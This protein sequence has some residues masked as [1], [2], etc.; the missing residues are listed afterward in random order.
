MA[1]TVTEIRVDWL[2]A[3]TSHEQGATALLNKGLEIIEGYV[4]SGSTRNDWSFQGYRGTRCESSAVGWRVDGC[5]IRLGGRAA[6]THWNNVVPLAGHVSRFDCAVTIQAEQGSGGYARAAYRSA[7]EAKPSVGRK[8]ECT[9]LIST[10]GGE[11]AYIGRRISDR[12]L[13]IYNKHAE[14]RGAYP[15]GT[16]RYEVEY[17]SGLAEQVARALILSTDSDQMLMNTVHEEMTRAGVVPPWEIDGIEAVRPTTV[18][19]QLDNARR[20]EWLKTSVRNSIDRLTSSYSEREILTALG[21]WHAPSM[22]DPPI[23]ATSDRK[24]RAK[25]PGAP[26]D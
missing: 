8:P 26:R 25:I 18:R 20:M 19:D 5:C 3:T 23:L 7:I 21:L 13:R 1:A 14:S 15:P 11:T 4:N 12:F 17:K 10:G 6:C 9:L 16:W 2:T 24:L 22:M